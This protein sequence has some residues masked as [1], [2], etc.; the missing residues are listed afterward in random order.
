MLA[1]TL[2]C[3]M[4]TAEVAKVEE[5]HMRRL[6]VCTMAAAL[7]TVSAQAE[8]AV[9]S[10]QDKGDKRV[11]ISQQKLKGQPLKSSSTVRSQ[12]QLSS[13]KLSGQPLKSTAP[14]KS[15]AKL[16]SKKLTGQPLKSSSQ[17]KSQK[18]LNGK[19]LSDPIRKKE[20]HGLKT[21]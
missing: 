14:L 18:K 8:Q 20:S 17:V 6:L 13:K 12:S 16:S 9:A 4:M 3:P 7:L 2:P 19:A 1:L 5:E 10:A 11:K 15:Q 21:R